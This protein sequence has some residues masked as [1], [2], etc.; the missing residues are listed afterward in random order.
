MVVRPGSVNR[1]RLQGAV[2]FGITAEEQRRDVLDRLTYC[3]TLKGA[4]RSIYGLLRESVEVGRRLERVAHVAGGVAVHVVGGDDQQVDRAVGR[5]RFAEGARLTVYGDHVQ[6]RGTCL[7]LKTSGHAFGG[8]VDTQPSSWDHVEVRVDL[9][10]R[11]Q[12]TTLEILLYTI[13]RVNFGVEIHDRKGLHGPVTL[14]VKGKEATALENWEIRAI[15]FDA[16]GVLPPLNW[17]AG[18]SKGPAFWRGSF[19]ASASSEDRLNWMSTRK[20]YGF[21]WPQPSCRMVAMKF[22]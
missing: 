16:D 14:R 18:K 11:T 20:A 19:E 8:E 7:A 6:A 12:S 5:A 3:Q 9:P 2:A 22:A 10:A 1:D 17:Q 15:D 4:M 13:A 21:H